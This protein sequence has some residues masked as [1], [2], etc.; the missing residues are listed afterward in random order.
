MLILFY[1]SHLLGHFS[2][3]LI[4]STESMTL[5]PG[6]QVNVCYHPRKES[7]QIDS[8]V[9]W[10]HLWKL[11]EEVDEKLNLVEHHTV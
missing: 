3:L 7:I 9:L 6:I 10:Y 4:N 5:S 1:F 11:N 8:D 2:S